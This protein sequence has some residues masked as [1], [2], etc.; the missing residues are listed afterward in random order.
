MALFSALQQSGPNLTPANF[1]RG[2]FSVP[3]S[4]G[5]SDF[6]RWS[7]AANYWSPLAS[8]SVQQWSPSGTSPYDGGTGGWVS[9]GGAVDYPYQGANLGS[10]QLNCFGH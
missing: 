5:T 7:N 8:F 1:A 10:G 3:N 6:G 9:C 4:T 2:W